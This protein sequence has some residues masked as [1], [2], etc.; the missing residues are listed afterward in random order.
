MRYKQRWNNF[1]FTPNGTPFFY[2]WVIIFAGT[3][4]VLA[5]APGQTT[6]V[7]TFTDYLIDAIGINRD[8]LSIAYLA[9]TILSSFALTYAGKL[10]D[11]YG[12]R[13]ISMGASIMLASILLILSQSDLLITLICN[14]GHS[15]YNIIAIIV[16]VLGFF[17]LRFS[18]QGVLTMVS[19]NMMMKWF[20]A[21]RGLVNGISAIF[22]AFGFSLAPLTFDWL[23]QEYSWRVAWMI[24]GGVIGVFFTTF[25]FIFFR[26]NPEDLGLVP[27]GEV[28]RNKGKDIIVKALKQFTLK[29][30]RKTITFWLF[31]IPLG[32]NAL[33][34]TGVTF[35]IVSIF[36]EAGL[37]R[38]SALAIFVP[39][40]FISV[41]V[42]LIGGWISDKLKLKY[43]LY[44][45]IIGEV[46]AFI[47]L[48][49]LDNGVFKIGVI[50]GVGIASGTY[51][52]LMAVTWPRFY[53]RD[54]LGAVT[55]FVMSI[56]VFLSALGPLL[57]STSFSYS[58]SYSLANYILLLVSAVLFV[59]ALKADNPQ[60]KF[61]NK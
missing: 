27:D 59:G 33:Y 11:K 24:L 36:D 18:G 3:V 55:G 60:D 5:S 53:G 12:A 1:P 47:C 40:S 42:S 14:K 56:I 13:W 35:N 49:H 39:V 29:E 50:I 8:E 7:S 61:A 28:H 4:G 16:M 21:R 51:N 17:F 48:A 9:G 23:I 2:G 58:G 19:R 30:A 20:I 43:L 10:Y 37:S 26:D 34:I 45:L 32:I 41:S 46:L 54:N 57:Y 38:D 25:A 6:G 52:V 15:A 44:L 31:A 22:V